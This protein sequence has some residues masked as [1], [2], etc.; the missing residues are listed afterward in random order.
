MAKFHINNENLVARCQAKK[1]RCPFTDYSTEEAAVAAYNLQRS[2]SYLEEM[3]RDLK[4]R[5]NVIPHDLNVACN[6]N[7]DT[8]GKGYSTMPYNV[9]MHLDEMQNKYGDISNV[10]VTSNI[11][12]LIFNHEK[13]QYSMVRTPEPDYNK[14][15]LVSRWNLLANRNG[16]ETTIPLDFDNNYAGTI[17]NLKEVLKR[18]TV[19]YGISHT[20]EHGYTMPEDYEYG[21]DKMVNSMTQTYI[22]TEEKLRGTQGMRD[23]IQANNLPLDTT[24]QSIDDANQIKVFGSATE[25]PFRAS[26]I[27][28]YYERFLPTRDPELNLKLY[29]DNNQNSKNIWELTHT[30]ESGWFVT[31]YDNDGVVDTVPMSSPEEAED[32]ISNYVR[33]NVQGSKDIIARSRGRYASTM[34]RD[35]DSAMQRVRDKRAAIEN[36]PRA[37]PVSLSTEN[38][39]QNQQEQNDFLD[40]T[41]KK[42]TLNTIL[43]LFS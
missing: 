40:T 23:H 18:D 15:V 37:K 5:S 25:S 39:E 36:A 6:I 30:P 28:E 7:A 16:K 26:M 42:S 8:T 22:M 9:A 20:K 4:I 17:E 43:G 35:V 24:I 14:G 41:K 27:D 11:H 1:N 10:M 31:T 32:Y 33:E 34:M 21:I 2:R 13:V 38:Y 19:F 29:D 3:R 12:D